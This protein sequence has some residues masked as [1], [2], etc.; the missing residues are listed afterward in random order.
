MVQ[1]L[2]V[3]RGRSLWRRLSIVSREVSLCGAESL[4][5]HMLSC[6]DTCGVLVPQPGIEPT[7]PALQGGLLATGPP[8]ESPEIIFLMHP[9][10]SP[11]PIVF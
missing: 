6:S 1:T 10:P 9:I 2:V 11:T 5:V 4:V 7:S 3:T 8:G